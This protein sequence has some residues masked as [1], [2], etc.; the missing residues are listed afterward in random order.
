VWSTVVTWL[1]KRKYGALEAVE[2][3]PIAAI[4]ESPADTSFAVELLNDPAAPMDLVVYTLTQVLRVPHKDAVAFMLK[5]HTD[6]SVYVGRLP[7][8][9][10][11]VACLAITSFASANGYAL[12]CRPVPVP[13]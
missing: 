4:A 7:E 10:A 13:A 12:T 2:G 8:A 11:I 9:V 5:A 1:A 6:G 3:V